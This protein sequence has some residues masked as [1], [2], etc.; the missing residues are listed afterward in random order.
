MTHTIKRGAAKTQRERQRIDD[1]ATAVALTLDAATHSLRLV[2]LTSQAAKTAKRVLADAHPKTHAAQMV[3]QTLYAA[4]Q[5]A[6]AADT[7]ARAAHDALWA[8]YDALIEIEGAQVGYPP[9]PS[10]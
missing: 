10:A 1:A 5:A 8:S 4:A 7:A 3:Y 6:Q 2:G 9:H